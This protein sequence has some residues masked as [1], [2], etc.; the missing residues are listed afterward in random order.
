MMRAMSFL[1]QYDPAGHGIQ[2]ASPSF[3]KVP[4]G[5]SICAPDTEQDFPAGQR[6]HS[7]ALP[8]EKLPDG[9]RN[10]KSSVVDGQKKPGLQDVQLL[11]PPVEKVPF[12]HG[13]SIAS[14]VD[15]QKKPAGQEVQEVEPSKA[16][17]PSLQV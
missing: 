2:F 4:N 5:Q 9:Q 13:F 7:I 12:G 16:Y 8:K 15:G 17:V 1:G 6:V 11:V 10:S 3:E 14:L